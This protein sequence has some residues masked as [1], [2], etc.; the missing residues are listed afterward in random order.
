MDSLEIIPSGAVGNCSSKFNHWQTVG[1]QC[2]EA[3]TMRKFFQWATVAT[4]LTLSANANAANTFSS[5][6]VDVSSMVNAKNDNVIPASFQSSS[7]CSDSCSSDACGSSCSKPLRLKSDGCDCGNWLQNTVAFS[8]V[9]AFKTIGDFI[10]PNN[11]GFVNGLNTG[12]RLGDSKIRGQVGGSY[13]VYDFKGGPTTRQTDNQGFLTTGIFKRSNVAASDNLSWGLVY[14]QLWNHQYGFAADDIYLGQFRGILGVALT[15]C[16][17]VGVWGTAH[18][19]TF[20]SSIY[21]PLKAINQYNLFWSHNYAFGARSMVYA[22][23]ADHSSVGSWQ[24]GTQL[25]APMSSR[26][27]LYG[28]SAFMFPSSA[29]GSFAG[30]S[31]LLWSVSCGMSFSFGR[32][33]VSRNISGQCGMPLQQVANNGTFMID[34]S[35]PS[36]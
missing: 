36:N 8:G 19:N 26:V 33:T 15:Q 7:S 27:S 4:V 12:F 32:K 3:K 31:E 22:G 2:T 21:G 6:S 17:E 14:D 30:A 35:V 24:T 1:L 29:T 10:F 9:E 20:N 25:I 34:G 18:T 16:D 28:N 23:L 5:K 13:G 11:A